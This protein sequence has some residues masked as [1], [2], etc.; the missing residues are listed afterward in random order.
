MGWISTSE[1]I[2]ILK[3]VIMILEVELRTKTKVEDF[4]ELG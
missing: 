1:L 2:K 3:D 4:M